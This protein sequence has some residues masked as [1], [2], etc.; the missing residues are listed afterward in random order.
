MGRFNQLN[1]DPFDLLSYLN[2]K[3]IKSND[4][5]ENIVLFT[6]ERQQK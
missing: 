3:I 1:S 2:E 5:S 6:A 4:S